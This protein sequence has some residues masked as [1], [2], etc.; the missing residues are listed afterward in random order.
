LQ[1]FVTMGKLLRFPA[2]AVVRGGG[3]RFDARLHSVEHDGLKRGWK[4]VWRM[5]GRPQRRAAKT[6]SLVRTFSAR[7]PTPDPAPHFG[8]RI[9]MACDHPANCGS[10]SARSA[11][12]R[13]RGRSRPPAS[14]SRCTPD[15]CGARAASVLGA[16]PTDLVYVY[17]H[18][19]AVDRWTHRVRPPRRVPRLADGHL[20][21]RQLRPRQS[22]RSLT[23]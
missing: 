21:P 8:R 4:R 6:A 18:V 2:F 16:H 23:H 19:L 9:P 7:W 15:R 22:R 11:G 5:V 20:T 17:R 13:L 14:R 10:S 3:I 1:G 12:S